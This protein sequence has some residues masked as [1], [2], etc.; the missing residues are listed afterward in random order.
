MM[1]TYDICCAACGKKL[2]TVELQDGKKYPGAAS[3]GMYC[4]ETCVPIIQPTG[5]L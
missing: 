4:T 2:G 1:K 5:D 3:Y